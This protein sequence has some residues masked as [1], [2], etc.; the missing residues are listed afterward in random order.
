[1]ATQEKCYDITV[2]ESPAGPGLGDGSSSSNTALFVGA[3]IA[4]AALASSDGDE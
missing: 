2:R 3:G 4:L 1:M